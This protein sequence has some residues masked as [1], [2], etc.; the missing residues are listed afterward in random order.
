MDALFFGV[1]LSYI[2]NFERERFDFVKRNKKLLVVLVVLLLI[3]DFWVGWTNPFILIFTLTTNSFCFAILL[4]LALDSNWKLFKL[5]PLVYIGRY[6]YSIYLW[7]V[8]INIYALKFI[9][10][11][12]WDGPNGT[13][14]SVPRWF[15]YM[16]V[17]FVLSIFTGALFTQLIEDPFLKSRDKYFPSKNGMVIAA[18]AAA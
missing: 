2:S 16:G 10:S 7:H 6:S 14:T 5:R 13:I 4:V 15:A 1:L 9:L 18:Q 3:P 11:T 12:D 8:F 17:Y